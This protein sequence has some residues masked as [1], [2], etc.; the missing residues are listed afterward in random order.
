MPND[1]KTIAVSPESLAR[2]HEVSEKRV[3]NVLLVGAGAAFLLGVS[4]G[5]SA[6]TFHLLAQSR[7]MQWMPP[8]GIV[9][10]PNLKPFERFPAP[11]LTIDDDHD[12]RIH[13]DAAQSQKLNSYGWV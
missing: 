13:L 4:L 2:K 10:A 6:L 3:R 12:Q 8:L 9:T 1:S 11:H 7:P 5:A